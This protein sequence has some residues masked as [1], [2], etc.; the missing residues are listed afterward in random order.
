MNKIFYLLVLLFSIFPLKI[1]AHEIDVV[2]Q[3]SE[4]SQNLMSSDSNTNHSNQEII[5]LSRQ[6]WLWMAERNIESLTHL[7]HD[8]AVFVHMGAT[9]S[10][11]EELNVI[12]NGYI[13]YKHAEIYETSVRFIGNTAILLNRI[14]MDSI[15]DGREVSNPFQVTEIYIKENEVWKLGSL[16]FTRLVTH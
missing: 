13:Q 6:K 16:S 5:D 1:L 3:K 2:P 7:F 14:R 9:F 11:L 4:I 12:Q 15:V 8:K 10:K